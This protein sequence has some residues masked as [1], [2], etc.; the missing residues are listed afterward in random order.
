[1]NA[2]NE[3]HNLSLVLGDGVACLVLDS[4]VKRFG[5]ISVLTDEGR[6]FRDGVVFAP[7]RFNVSDVLAEDSLVDWQI[8]D[9]AVHCYFSKL[10]K[11]F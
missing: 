1:M 11:Y 2:E 5:F 7:S 10:R 9:P 4:L 3:G 6:F 8:S